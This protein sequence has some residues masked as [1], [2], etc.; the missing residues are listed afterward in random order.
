MEEVSVRGS[1]ILERIVALLNLDDAQLDHVRFGA[2][3]VAVFCAILTLRAA[4]KAHDASFVRRR[5]H[6]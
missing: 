6:R 1:S 5:F 3:V 4:K 2:F